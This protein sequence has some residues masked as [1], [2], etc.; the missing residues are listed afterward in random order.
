MALTAKQIEAGTGLFASGVQ[1][2][3]VQRGSEDVF[4]TDEKD[5]A[6]RPGWHIAGGGRILASGKPKVE[7]CD[8]W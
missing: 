3:I 7:W 6:V 8:M 1:T 5:C 4:D 2:V